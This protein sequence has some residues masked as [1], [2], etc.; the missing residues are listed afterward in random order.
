MGGGGGGEGEGEGGVGGR[1]IGTQEPPYF[2]YKAHWHDLFYK[3]VLSHEN[4]P[5]G[6]ENRGHCSFSPQGKITQK[7]YR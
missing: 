4:I 2:L 5:N 7:I 1:R 6:I 3:T